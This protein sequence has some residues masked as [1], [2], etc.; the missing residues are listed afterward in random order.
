MVRIKSLIGQDKNKLKMQKI[1]YENYVNK[2]FRS[3]NK[4]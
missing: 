3:K 1:I 2:T 4:L